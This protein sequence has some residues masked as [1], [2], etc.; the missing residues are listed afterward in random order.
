MQDKAILNEFAA[1]ITKAKILHDN[2]QSVCQKLRREVAQLE[3]DYHTIR[4]QREAAE[5]MEKS[6]QN[7]LKMTQNAEKE[8]SAKCKRE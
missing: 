6:L 8:T 3:K 5:N 4:N 7:Q 1:K 2:T